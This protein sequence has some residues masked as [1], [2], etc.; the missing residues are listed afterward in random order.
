MSTHSI[1]LPTACLT[2]LLAGC[3]EPPTPARASLDAPSFITAAGDTVPMREVLRIGRLDG[4]DEYTFAGVLWTLQ[5]P[6]RGV[7]LYDLESNDLT[8]EA[9]R[10]R[11]YDSAGRFV[12]R[13]GRPGE[14]PGEHR[15]FP[16]ATLLT[17][18]DL[19]IADQSLARFTR[20]NTLGNLVGTWPGPS[21]I[22]ELQAA[23]DGGWFAATVTGPS[24]G[25][26]RRIEYLRYDSLGNEIARFPAPDAYHEGPA[27]PSGPGPLPTSDVAILPDGRMVSNRSDSLLVVIS[28]QSGEVRVGA[29]H[30]PVAYKPGEADALR[31][32]VAG[33]ATRARMPVSPIEILEFKPAVGGIR[34][35]RG[36][37]VVLLLR[38]EAYLGDTTATLR[39]NQS[40]W[41]E[42][43]V[44]A[45]F[46]ST[47]TYRGRLVTPRHILR[48]GASFSDDA[49]WLVEEGE[50]GELYLVKWVPE[51][52]VW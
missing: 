25:K 29:P 31:A 17:N 52:V 27:G 14:G 7:I 8:G 40:P 43:M 32:T 24:Q 23:T 36:G 33:R 3:A 50:S 39:A 48:R 5:T 35:D 46:D 11:Q 37:R 51:S 1:I 41:R 49:V 18:G 13:I 19:L 10:L 47:A 26:P 4:P 6:D 16:M 45:L 20:F 34:V 44:A 22:V 28:S 12:R 38:T 15:S 2:L 21:A 30:E 9:G 42:P